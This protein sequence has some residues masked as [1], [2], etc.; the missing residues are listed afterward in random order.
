MR[1]G[2]PLDYIA[3]VS[4]GAMADSLYEYLPKEFMLLGGHHPEYQQMYEKAI[5]R[6]KETLFFRPLNAENRDILLSGTAQV[7]ETGVELDTEGQHLVC[8]VGGMV[9]TAARLFEH[10]EDLR[11]ARK[12]VDGCIWAYGNTVTGLMPETF[13]A[14]QCTADCNWKS[15]L[16]HQAALDRAREDFNGTVESFIEQNRLS[17]GFA[18]IPDRRYVLRPEAIESIFILYRI[19]GDESLRDEAWKMFQSVEKW[20][21][22]D[23]AHAVIWDVTSP[24]AP[25][26][27]RMET[28]FTAETLKYYFLLYAEPHIIS[29][30]DY[31]FNTE[32]HPLKRPK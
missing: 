12:L 26:G 20:T 15:P 29:L 32:A 16:W 6:A 19:T 10:P 7:H 31:V 8:F 18:D 14:V 22:T 11:V 1:F 24:D 5:K 25:K 9:A 2:T 27:D 4:K 17:P 13:H 3:K 21:R 30:D 23:I 28:F